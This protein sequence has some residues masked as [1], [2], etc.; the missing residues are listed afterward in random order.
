MSD[1]TAGKFSI[2]NV[3][4]PDNPRFQNF[5]GFLGLS[6]EKDSRGTHWP[7]RQKVTD[8]VNEIFTWGK[9][10]SDS[11]DLE[12]IKKEV[13][14]LKRS[15]GTNFIGE[16]L[17]EQLWEFITFDS[18]SKITD[19]DRQQHQEKELKIL[20][21][22]VKSGEEVKLEQAKVEKIKARSLSKVKPVKQMRTK[23]E[24]FEGSPVKIIK[25]RSK[26]VKEELIEI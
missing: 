13:F 16:T 5:A 20:K 7:Y 4:W 11:Q 26:P 2:E 17:V 6:L 18:K 8:K 3:N 10:R 21:E 22:F 15:V 9:I 23:I 12:K 19:K 14:K 1:F 24:K 25:T